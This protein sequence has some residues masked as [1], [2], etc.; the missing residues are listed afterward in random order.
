MIGIHLD[1]D[2]G[3]AEPKASDEARIAIVSGAASGI[4]AA[5]VEALEGEGYRVAGLDLRRSRCALPLQVD[6]ADA[7]AVTEAVA[8]TA[9]QLGAAGALV[10]AAGYFE[11]VEIAAMTATQ[12][13][14]MLEVHLGGTVNLIGAVLPAMLARGSGSIVTIASDLAL[15]GVAGGSHYAAAKGALIGLTRS[16]GVELAPQGVTVNCVGPGPTDT[17]LVEARTRS[18]EY[19]Q[20]LP[21]RRLVQPAEVA[22]TVAFLLANPRLY[23]GQVLSPNAGSAI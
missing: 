13:D 22:T 2:P 4:G 21:L 23:V 10:T 9:I 20:S 5:V 6:V 12:W 14:R 8:E 16:L 18:A 3:A 17:P 15:V 1:A 19:R 11:R 7:A